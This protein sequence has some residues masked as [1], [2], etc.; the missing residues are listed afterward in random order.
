MKTTLNFII[1]ILCL[2]AFEINAQC[3][4]VLEFKTGSGITQADVDDMKNFPKRLGTFSSEQNLIISHID[5]QTQYGYNNW[6]IP[7]NEKLSLLSANSYM[8]IGDYMSRE[9]KPGKVLLVI[10]GG[11]NAKLQAEEKKK[12]RAKKHARQYVDLGLSSGTKWRK[13]NEEGDFYTYDQAV[14]KFGSAL[15]TKKQFEE[16]KNS[17]QWT[18]IGNGYKVVGPN[19]KSIIL[20]AAGYRYCIG[21]V[22]DVGSEGYYWSTTSN[23][24]DNAWGLFI[25]S[26][27]VYVNDYYQCSGLSV[28]LVQNP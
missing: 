19:G 23:G 6:C 11:K 4:A 25:G 15:P 1:A 12:I 26:E 14:S 5:A 7:T 17:C 13:E 21:R 24:S 8:G 28:R 2:M 16:L 3:S 27:K 10:D 20:P 22:S 18:W 9:N